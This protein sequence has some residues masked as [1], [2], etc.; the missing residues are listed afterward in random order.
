MKLRCRERLGGFRTD[1]AGEL[2]LAGSESVG[3]GVWLGVPPHDD[4]SSGFPINYLAIHSTPLP[5]VRAVD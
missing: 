5:R 4:L 3:F 1:L 2:R